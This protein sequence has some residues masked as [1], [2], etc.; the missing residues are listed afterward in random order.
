[1]DEG[2]VFWGFYEVDELVGVMD[3]F[4]ERASSRIAQEIK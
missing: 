3:I 4:F 1:M 2:L